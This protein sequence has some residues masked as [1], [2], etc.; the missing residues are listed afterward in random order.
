MLVDVGHVLGQTEIILRVTLIS[1]KPEE[2]EAREQG[3]W[4]LDVDLGRLLDVVA[5]E[6]WVGSRQD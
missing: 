4:Q 6:G 1:D 5:A 3:C 2:V